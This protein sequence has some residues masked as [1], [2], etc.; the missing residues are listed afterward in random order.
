MFT[1]CVR[2]TIKVELSWWT[3]AC[4]FVFIL[5]FNFW[6]FTRI[7]HWFFLSPVPCFSHVWMGVRIRNILP[8][9]VIREKNEGASR[10]CGSNKVR[11]SPEAQKVQSHTVGGI[12]FKVACSKAC[13]QMSPVSLPF[14]AGATTLAGKGF[15][16]L[17]SLLEP[18]SWPY[19]RASL[20]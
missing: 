3:L 19:N 8:W 18:Q 10:L 7:L 9:V 17:A 4:V 11:H 15:V 16:A 5:V 20:D 13:K 12:F 14:H 6:G 1:K 2:A